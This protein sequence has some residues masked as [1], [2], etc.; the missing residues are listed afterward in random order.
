ME[1]PQA[2]AARSDTIIIGTWRG[3][4]GNWLANSVSQVPRK[5]LLDLAMRYERRA[6]NIDARNETA[7]PNHL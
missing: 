2:N 3:N 6:D 4:Y 5:E 7:D 1:E